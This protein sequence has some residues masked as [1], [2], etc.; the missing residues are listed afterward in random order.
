MNRVLITGGGGFVGKA[1]VKQL[2]KEGVDCAVIGRNRYPELEEKGV[3]CLQGDISNRD[4]VINSLKGFD[5]VFHVAALAGIW[6]TWERYYKT[7]VVGTENVIL[8]CKTNNIPV[9]VYTSTPSVVFDRKDIVNGDESLPYPSTFLC[10]YAKSKV[11]AEKLILSVS[12][13]ELNT[14]SIRP[15]LIWGPD[16]PHLIPRLIQRGKAGSLKIIGNG[17]N[18]VDITYIDN[19]AH[20]HLLAAKNLFTSKTAAGNAYFIGQERPVE[21]WSWV[22]EIFEKLDIG[23][24]RQKVSLPVALAAGGTLEFLFGLLNVKN[25]PRMTRFLAEQLAKSHYFSHSLAKKDLGYQP[26]ISIEEG[27]D[28]LMYWLKS[29]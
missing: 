2:Q 26:I 27:M 19:V 9:L 14:C 5:T 13:E 8:G 1:L 17:L 28:R 6:G 20:A 11:I 10:N 18:K 16:D 12:Q 23:M 25:E 29:Q 15:H 24:V 3:K 22:N 7:N 21:L 4:F